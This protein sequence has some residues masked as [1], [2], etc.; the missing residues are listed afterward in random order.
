[1]RRWELEASADLGVR[2]EGLARQHDGWVKPLCH[3]RV[4]CAEQKPPLLRQKTPE[5]VI[6]RAPGCA[7][8]LP[9]P[10]W[11]RSHPP[12]LVPVLA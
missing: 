9:C 7:A 12:M 11:L 4:A 1:M 6:R 5:P 3:E 10:R 8:V 2:D